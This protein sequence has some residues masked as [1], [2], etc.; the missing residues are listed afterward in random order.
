MNIVRENIDNLSATLKVT[1]TPEDYAQIVDTTLKGYKKKANV[2]G[3]RPGMVPMGI[4][5]KM[6]KKGV[7]A[8]ESYK[9]A[10]QACFDYI[11]ENKINA[12]GDLMP[13][14]AQVELD[15]DNATDF[16]FAFEIGIAPEVNIELTKK[17][18][19]NKYIINVSDEM[20]IGYKSNYT[21]RFGKL[22]DTDVITKDE[23]VNVT[24]DQPEM[25]IEDAYVGL[26]S[27]NDEERKP[28]IG[29]KVGDSME[30][31]VNE[32]YKTPSQRASIMQISE[33]ELDTINPIF[34]L[35]ITKIRKF[36]E[37]KID[38]E[39]F[40][41]AFPEGEIKTEKEFSEWI[42]KQIENELGKETEFKFV[43]DTR[44]FLINKANIELP[45]EFLKKWLYNIND[46]KFSMEEI[47]KDF[48][49]FLDI[50]R[51]DLIKK[52]FVNKHEI[53][54]D[55][56]EMMAEAKAL[57]MMQFAQ[58]G[59]STLPDDMLE[60]YAKSILENK[61]EARKIYDKLMET[62]VVEVVA[63]QITA[64][65]TKISVEDFGKLFEQKA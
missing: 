64:K 9:I 26:V 12:I 27:M 51:W 24:L 35:T 52:F 22:A 30:V 11:N 61:E 56:E 20:R 49:N 36:E 14:E 16:E 2:P 19:V 59:M 3:F 62:K 17:D 21:R 38:E 18:T 55:N 42:E 44:D 45:K 60:N 37:P 28:F 41:M 13:S 8:E 43:A 57:T 31:N 1:V 50:M 34:T 58:Y 40:K 7:T 33:N 32:L 6:Y 29:K 54:V 15:F 39:F 47:E 53:E 25:Q 4:V 5:N 10:S 23:A 63:P 65:D 48:E 46:G